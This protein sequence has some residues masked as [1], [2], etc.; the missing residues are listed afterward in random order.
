MYRDIDLE[1]INKN[2]DDIKN[3]A[4]MEFKIKYEPTLEENKQIYK[5]IQNYIKKNNRIIYGGFAQHLLIKNKNPKDGVYFEIDGICFNY[6]EIADMEFYSPEPLEDIVNLTNELFNLNYK[7]IEAKEAIHTTTYKIFVNT[8]NYCDFAYMPL[9]IYNNMPIIT[10]EGFKLCHP[11]FMLV[12]AFRVFNDPL[13]SYWRLEKPL[14]RFQ[15]ILKY[16][17]IENYNKEIIIPKGDIDILKFIR[18]K[19]IHKS[20]FIVIG[21]YGY[22]YYMKKIDKNKLVNISHY[23]IISTNLKKDVLS[24]YNKLTKH[25]KNIKIENFFPF[26]DFI[27]NRVEFYYNDKLILSVLG[28]KERCIVYNY[29][30]KKKTYFGTNNLIFMHLL[31]NYIYFYI[32]KIKD[33]TELYLKLIKSFYYN[34]KDYLYKHNLTVIDKSPFQDFT[35]K[36]LGIHI[37]PKRKS[38]LL[39]KKQKANKKS[40][41]FIYTPNGKYTKLQFNYPNI[42]GNKILKK[43]YFILK[44]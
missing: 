35:I 3:N 44:K 37:D 17:P 40:F 12:D 26:Y 39:G 42:S 11:F 22:N 14:N 18:K 32:S 10:Y 20:S 23:E 29:S 41:K 33:D 13:T 36:C 19:I 9:K 25:F 15:K 27:D 43:K 7:F 38:Y 24:I 1:A 5:I 21:F 16:Y 8:V 28:N 30:E 2:L 34:K 4:V 6:P 31:Y